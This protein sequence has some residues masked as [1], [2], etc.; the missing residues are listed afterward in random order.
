M[1]GTRPNEE[2]PENHGED[3]WHSGNE[4][5]DEE[6]DGLDLTKPVP[7]G[8][9]KSKRIKRDRQRDIGSYL[10]DSSQIELSDDES[11]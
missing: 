2:E 7:T 11:E 10:I 4:D 3:V 9:R 1:P 5:S 6:N 8:E